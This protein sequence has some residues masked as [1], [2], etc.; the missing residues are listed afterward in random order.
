[1]STVATPKDIAMDEVEV[2]D[3]IR[4]TY[5]EPNDP[6]DPDSSDT[7]ITIKGKVRRISASRAPMLWL[8][9]QNGGRYR[10]TGTGTELTLGTAHTLKPHLVTLLDRPFKPFV[11]ED[12]EYYLLGKKD[13]RDGHMWRISI[14]DSQTVGAWHRMGN[15]GMEQP[16]VTNYDWPSVLRLVHNGKPNTFTIND[17]PPV[18]QGIWGKEYIAKKRPGTKANDVIFTITHDLYEKPDAPEYLTGVGRWEYPV[19]YINPRQAVINRAKDMGVKP[20]N[21]Y[22]CFGRERFGVSAEGYTMYSNVNPP[23]N[24]T[25]P[26]HAIVRNPMEILD[27]IEQ[28][29]LQLVE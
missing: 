25:T 14:K 8:R 24:Q 21:V 19:E 13:G 15:L 22:K 6:E 26:L 20:E 12:R 5:V 16:D 9:S 29:T 4:V 28:G 18:F 2:G 1:M 27:G 17:N 23:A 10:A 3:I 11:L 7:E